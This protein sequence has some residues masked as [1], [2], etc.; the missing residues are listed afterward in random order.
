[1]HLGRDA[2]TIDIHN[3]ATERNPPTSTVKST[4]LTNNVPNARG[5]YEIRLPC[6]D[7][8]AKEFNRPGRPR[9]WGNSLHKAR[10]NYYTAS[11]R[12]TNLVSPAV[13]AT[14][15]ALSSSS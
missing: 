4:N 8:T 14:P 7:R 9:H 1:M 12:A 15:F 6:N 11:P 10:N 2:S 13:Q 5:L 3:K